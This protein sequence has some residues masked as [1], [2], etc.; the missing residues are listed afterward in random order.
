MD[1]VCKSTIWI[2]WPS[3]FIIGCDKLMAN[4]VHS[5][6]LVNINTTL[7]FS[8][9]ASFFELLKVVIF[10]LICILLFFSSLL[11][12]LMLHF[13]VK[14]ECRWCFIWFVADC[15]SECNWLCWLS[16]F[17]SIFGLHLRLFYFWS[18][19]SWDWKRA[20]HV[21]SRRSATPPS[22]WHQLLH[23]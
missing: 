15:T 17:D 5:K 16:R 18:I 8:R 22:D 6:A 11:K 21:V 13:H 4:W 19:S 9:S 2:N 23:D 1:G 12:L 14:V 10:I 20:W 3:S 7:K